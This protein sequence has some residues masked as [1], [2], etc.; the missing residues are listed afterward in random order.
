MTDQSAAPSAT[1]QAQGGG[2]PGKG[3]TPGAG[4]NQQQNGNDPVTFADLAAH[5]TEIQGMLNSQYQGIQG[6]LD[7]QSGNMAKAMEPVNRLM[8]SLEGMGIELTPE[9]QAELRSGEASHALSELGQP[10][11][12][13]PGQGND[14]PNPNEPQDQ[15]GR[16]NQLALDTMR[17][18]GVVLMATDEEMA[19]VDQTTEDPKVF[20]D[21]LDGALTR[22]VQRLAGMD[23]EP[24]PTGEGESDDSQDREPGPGP[25]PRGSGNK[26]TNL[27]PEKTPSGART[28]PIDYLTAGYSESDAFP[29]EE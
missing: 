17:S 9:Q 2:A 8:A 12:G 6:L 25:N 10:A 18:R 19:L 23:V 28:E 5:K 13:E 3:G 22:K 7:R 29:S 26:P 11:D 16:F 20:L 24:I 15:A 21:S 4:G 14:Q 1:S 27:L